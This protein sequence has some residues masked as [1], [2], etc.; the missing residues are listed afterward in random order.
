MSRPRGETEYF[1]LPLATPPARQKE[2]IVSNL[3]GTKEI[4]SEISSASS[5]TQRSPSESLVPGLGTND[6]RTYGGTLVPP[7]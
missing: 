7:T 5:E 1:A 2:R 3:T 6:P 4:G